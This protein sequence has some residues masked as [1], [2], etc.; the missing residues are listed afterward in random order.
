MLQ[1]LLRKLK[2]SLWLLPSVY[3]GAGLLL[4]ACTI[5]IDM[6]Y[7]EKMIH[8]IP[9]IF[10]TSVDL[11]KTILDTL[12]SALLT[13]T[14]FT[15]SITMIVLT[16]YSS[17]F[18]PRAL[19]NFM[20]EKT[21][22]RVLGIFLGG[23]VYSI[24][25]LVFMRKS[26]ENEYVIS[27]SVG[28]LITIVCLA[29]FIH[30]VHFIGKSIQVDYLIEKLTKEIFQSIN[31]I[32]G[33]VKNKQVKICKQDSFQSNYQKSHYCKNP[34]Y[35][36]MVNFDK[37][38]SFAKTHNVCIKIHHK[39]G[40]YITEN[41]LVFTIFSTENDINDNLMKQCE[42]FI[43]LSKN[44]DTTQDISFAIQK[45]VEIALRA[46]SPAINDPYT[47]KHCIRNIG[48]VL[49]EAS[50]LF[51]GDMLFLDK[52]NNP[53]ILIPMEDFENLLYYSFYQ[54]NVESKD[55]LPIIGAIIDALISSAHKSSV[56][57]KKSIWNFFSYITFYFIENQSL[58]SFDV[59]YLNKKKQMLYKATH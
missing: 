36:Q 8:Y 47:A 10:L 39:I 7:L 30:F 54:F 57:N 11:A 45:L 17:Q 13:M 49:A 14:T 41:S 15:F 18:S 53:R 32:Q 55:D 19:P 38:V 25:S 2:D 42:E 52:Q 16:T 58:H 33:R 34:L 9:E 28:V 40:D 44:R 59:E 12:S 22:M 31:D 3:A 46:T 1:K 35:L 29:F 50:P 5:T 51:E 24:Y 21:T 37:L 48:K 20:K 27:A 43:T 4:A 56:Q 26:I 23:F 6:N